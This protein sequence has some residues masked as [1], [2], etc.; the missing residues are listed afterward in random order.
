MHRFSDFAEDDHQLEG[1][2]KSIDDILGTEI[3]VKGYRLQDSKYNRGDGKVLTIQFELN[4]QTFILFTG[5]AVLK[6]QI[7]KYKDKLPF[8][9]TIQRVN[10]YYSFT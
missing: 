8:M 6:K 2:K 7:Q 9:A 3:A 10:K 5:S 4:E 1:D